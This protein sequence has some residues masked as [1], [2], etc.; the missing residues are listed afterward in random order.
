MSGTRER[1]NLDINSSKIFRGRRLGVS[2]ERQRQR[3][4]R[5]QRQRYF[6]RLLKLRHTSTITTTTTKP[7]PHAIPVIQSQRAF[8]EMGCEEEEAEER[9]SR[10]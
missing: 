10:A 9:W 3:H 6:G 5:H 7:T 8:S 4:Q 1:H 2:Q